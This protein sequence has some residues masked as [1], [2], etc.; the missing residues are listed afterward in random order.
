ME[1]RQR[2]ANYLASCIGSAVDDHDDIF[3][4]G[5]VNSLFAMQLVVFIEQEFQI[6]VDGEDL[7]LDNFC[8]VDAMSA[9]VSRK[10]SR[11][12]ADGSAS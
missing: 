12:G 8:S 11:N 10:L 2:I 7:D 4:R 5:L 6:A 9:F 1:I 3:K